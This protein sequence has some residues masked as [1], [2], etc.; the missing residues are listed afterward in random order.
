M[1]INCEQSQKSKNF[2]KK[3]DEKMV[4][5][6]SFFAK[7]FLSKNG[8]IFIKNFFRVFLKTLI[9]CG[10]NRMHGYLFDNSRLS[11]LQPVPFLQRLSF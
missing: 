2:H 5:K 4:K 8:K 6:E 7:K 10:L 3:V 1:L 9:L 11:F